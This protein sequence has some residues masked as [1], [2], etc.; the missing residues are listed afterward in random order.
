MRTPPLRLALFA[1]LTLG[2]Q[3]CGEISSETFT[4]CESACE[5]QQSEGCTSIGDCKLTCDAST[6]LAEQAQCQSQYDAYQNCVLTQIDVC[7]VSSACDDLLR[8]FG[9][10]TT[11]FC[12][13]HVESTACRILSQ[14]F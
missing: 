4:D 11:G 12:V 5:A 7:L 14:S 1:L 8:K 9:E 10:C 3:A 2:S 6:T 13:E